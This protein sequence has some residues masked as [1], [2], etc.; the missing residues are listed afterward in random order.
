MI[1]TIKNADYS[2]CG[3]GR[4]PQDYTSLISYI[5]ASDTF[6]TAFQDF[7]DEIGGNDGSVWRKIKYLIIPCLSADK[8]EAATID[9][10]FFDVKNQEV[11][12][13]GNSSR[14]ESYAS[15]AGIVFD[16]ETI[17]FTTTAQ[18]RPTL[19][20]H[21]NSD[22][23]ISVQAG[24]LTPFALI[25]HDN[26]ENDAS[27]IAFGGGWSGNESSGQWKFQITDANN[28]TLS[29]T[30]SDLA[31]DKYKSAVVTVIDQ[32]LHAV[33]DYNS[34]LFSGNKGTSFVESDNVSTGVPQTS[35]QAG[36]ANICLWGYAEG[37]TVEEATI[38]NTA[39]KNFVD[40]LTSISE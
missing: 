8:S 26:Y 20:Y 11:H 33:C 22:D 36:R 40:V 4:L 5:G 39:F 21:K 35:K 12:Y 6:K 29:R 28:H 14:Q 27:C 7:M 25:R 37:F 17:K 16:N 2:A 23:I 31:K 32:T 13:F 3:L 10:A 34:V 24:L 18:N 9:K 30:T 15:G 19:L 38:L 1:I